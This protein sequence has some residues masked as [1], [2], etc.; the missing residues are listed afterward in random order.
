MAPKAPTVEDVSLLL[1]GRVCLVCLALDG[2]P[3][4]ASPAPGVFSLSF[5][6]G[7]WCHLDTIKSEIPWLSPS[8]IFDSTFL[9]HDSTPYGA[10]GESGMPSCLCI[11]GTRPWGCS[12][13]FTLGAS[14]KNPDSTL[15]DGP[16]VSTFV[17]ESRLM[18]QEFFSSARPCFPPPHSQCKRSTQLAP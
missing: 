4:S 12:W 2:P 15:R 13:M 7:F 5:G 17:M 10:R 6:A 18:E 3:V 1:D 14:S 9:F 11:H 8:G 16:Q